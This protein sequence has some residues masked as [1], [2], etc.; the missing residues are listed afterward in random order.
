MK[1]RNKTVQTYKRNQ[2]HFTNSHPN[3]DPRMYLLVVQ[4]SFFEFKKRKNQI[5]LAVRITN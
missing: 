2:V 5:L 4:A 3:N 1:V